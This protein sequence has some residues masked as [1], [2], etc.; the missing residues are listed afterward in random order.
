[1]EDQ[2]GLRIGCYEYDGTRE[3]LS[4]IT[5]ELFL[6]R[7]FECVYNMNL[8]FLVDRDDK[9]ESVSSSIETVRIRA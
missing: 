6:L 7:P 5:L 2:M 3:R 1:M 9:T 8:I 4:H